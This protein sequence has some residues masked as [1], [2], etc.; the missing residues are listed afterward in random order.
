MSQPA[1]PGSVSRSDPD[2]TDRQRQVFAALV[3]LH[4]RAAGPVG[5]ETL[6]LQSGI[7]LS[8]A[9]IRTALAELEGMG[10]LERPRTSAG[11]VP[12][13]GGFELYVRTLLEPDTLPAGILAEVDRAL[14]SS[15]RDIE[16]LL[17]EASR[18]LSSL[19]LQLGLALAA[20]LDDEQVRDIELASLDRRRSLMVLNLGGA[21]VRT[22]VLELESPLERDQLVMV[23]A[24]LRERLVG[25][26]LSEVRERLATDPD[27]ARHSAVRVVARAAMAGWSR[28]VS[29]Q[30]FAAGAMHIAE[31]PEFAS[32]AQL[33]S[34]L[35]VVEAG[36]PLD[37]L[38]MASVEGEVAVRVGVDEDRALAGCS[39]VSYAL[40][41]TVRGAVGVLGPLR[42]DYARVLA[43]VDAVGSRVSE[44]L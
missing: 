9:S 20:S 17:N 6:A 19:T 35:R 22:V 16:H 24:V 32:S 11:R 21:S 34:I 7:P 10:L 14:L 42:M 18:L 31:H 12:T 23:Q 15:T 30:R 41:G 28:P 36:R 4:R 25:R 40:P 33:G 3:M 26:P 27:L 39:L 13:A 29:T 5:S 2:L 43:A 37:R 1:F 38:M 44:L 8:P